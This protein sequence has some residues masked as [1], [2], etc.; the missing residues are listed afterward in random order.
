MRKGSNHSIKISLAGFVFL[1]SS[2]Q[3]VAQHTGNNY[4]SVTPVSYVRTWDVTAPEL[5]PN[6]LMARPLKDVKQTTQ[7]IDG[8]GR[9]LQTVIKMGSLVTDPNNPLSSVNATD[10][11]SPVEYDPFGREQYKWLP[12]KSTATDGNFR[13]SPFNEQPA[14]YSS[15]NTASP[16]YN[17][18]ENYFYSKTNFEPSPLNRITD[19]YAPGISWAG[20]EGNAPAQQRNVQIQYTV[21]TTNDAVR[22]WTVTDNSTIGVFGT[23][24][25]SAV[26][27]A[28]ELYKTITTD[29]HKKQVIEF[30]DK[31][32]KT[33]LRKVQLTAT[34]DD[35]SGKDYTGWL[36]TYY[37]YDD[38]GNLR[39]VIQPEGVK[40]IL[41]TWSLTQA[42]LD[43]QC[44]RY[45]YDQRNRTITKKVPGAGEVWMVYDAL[46][47]LVMTQ[48]ANMRSSSQQK[49]LY[50]IY[51][52]LNRPQS[53]GLITDPTNYNNHTAH[54]N[55]AYNSTAY[56]NVSSYTNEELTH[57]FYDDYTWLG[58]YG[59]PLPSTYATTYD[60]YFQPASN[61]EWP[62][63]QANTQSTV[64]ND[65]ATGS[66]TKILGTNNYLYTVIFYDAK[67]RVIQTQSTNITG[68]TDIN[69]TQ[70]TWAGQ[71]LVSVQKQ[72]KA[73][74]NAQTT[75]V[76]SQ[77]TYDNLGRLVK[78]E[79]KV[80]NT[81]VNSNAMPA[82]KTTVQN[83]YNALGQIKT[84]KLAPAYNSNAGLETLNYD[85]NIRGWLLGA[86]REYAKDNNNSNYFG[87][88]LGYDKVNNNIIGNQTYNNPQYN[89]NI[90][91]MVWKSK[92]DG[93]KRKYDFGYDAVNRLMKADF[94]QY[95]GSVFNQSAGVNFNVKM[96]DGTMLSDG[97]SLD[98]TKAYDDN[99]NIL[100]MQQYGLKVNTS[101]QIDNLKYTYVAGSNRLKSV[102]DFNNDPYG[103][104]GDFKTGLLHP[105]STTKATLTPNSSPSQFNAI[106]DYSYDDNGNLNL[107]NNKAINSITYNYLNLPQDITFQVPPGW[108]QYGTGRSISYVYDAA[109][110]K[111]QKIVQESAGVGVN[112]NITTTYIN[113]FVYES[114]STNQG[115]SPDP[116]DH[117]DQ[118]QFIIHEEGRIRFI[119]STGTTVAS[120]QYDYMLKD[121]LSNVRMVLT[122]EQQVD[123]Y[124]PATMETATINTESTY[125]GN[126]TNTQT[127]KP[128]WFSDPLFPTNAQ[129]ATI[130]NTTGTQKIGPNIILKV[131][132]G[133]S[134]N[135]RVASGWNSTNSPSNDPVNVL[136]D[137]FNLLSS[138]VAN[139]SGGKA[140][141]SDL[142]S[143]SSGLNSGLSNF[144]SSQTNGGSA[145]K[146]YLNW[147][148]LDE[149]FR[150]AKDASGNIIASGYSGF[151]QVGASG[152]TKIHVQTLTVAKSG[153]LY[154]YTSN[155]A[156]N[157][158]VFF[159]NLQ[160]THNKGPIMEETHYYPFGLRMEGICSKAV[161][162]I[163][164]KYQYNGKES[165][166]KEL[167]DGNGL[168]AYDYGA[169]L[170]DVQLGMWHSIDPL[171]DKSRRW[172]P[173]NYAYNNPIR[174]IDPDG[175]EG[176]DSNDD[177]DQMVNFVRVR[178]TT[179]GEETNII[180]GIAK[181]GTEASY[182]E[183]SVSGYVCDDR[184]NIIQNGKDDY[185]VTMLQDNKA[186]RLG[187]LGGVLDTR[188]IIDNILSDNKK[189]AQ[190]IGG[191]LLESDR[192][193]TWAATVFTYSKWDYKNRGEGSLFGSTIFGIAFTF[194][195]D[196][197]FKTQFQASFTLFHDAADFGNYNAGYTGIYA[198]VPE[199][200]QFFFAGMG[201]V[202][203]NHDGSDNYNNRSSAK[204]LEEIAL[205]IAPYGDQWIDY[206]WNKKGMF[207]AKWSQR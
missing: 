140:S 78:T 32:G 127:A 84:K 132:A 38:L 117:P 199:G 69:T 111:L 142:Q 8:L 180:T 29:E 7:Y 139:N 155:E 70:Y 86:N 61:S 114:K 162:R 27:S 26:Y 49:W 6:N 16:V 12:Y 80:S 79:K 175:M 55:A 99:G 71:P 172:S 62:Y 59:N 165:Q 4:T 20:S 126:L 14:F 43:D 72:E 1:L 184:G 103:T 19:A 31:A 24:A 74:T 147:V 123:Q 97:I 17:Q 23:Y 186:T 33:I 101:V 152:T 37:I 41:S 185:N 110:N 11:V 191:K 203:K 143:T 153:Y 68:G 63:P 57:V 82:Y 15:T 60:T 164:N 195:K 121:H 156:T 98:P 91:G 193:I 138:G 207:D 145:P 44:F 194:D 34:A 21:N 157:I 176:E 189:E 92:G 197:A 205:K 149:Q 150:V 118:L 177:G 40:A 192:I 137:L 100:Q 107:D 116:D 52:N 170:L 30:K 50:T 130:K 56:P 89:G 178:S 35:G 75:V 106:T 181:E 88:D 161:N 159:D 94:T 77:L 18:G 133:D 113:G 25:S 104:L 201:E 202:M 58:T 93:E 66:R 169:R 67:G 73:G 166:S 206:I 190:E 196:K 47:R 3:L 96:G 125:Y 200:W 122:E 171:A 115:G 141:Y 188:V 83:E 154:I 53:T 148:L 168:E 85:Y 183:I 5:N 51:D 102:T 2:I 146:A 54:L 198:G 36:S 10:M 135:V 76:V 42:L 90:E 112:R 95:T 108:P 119:P 45:E 120:L 167:S 179:T 158:D 163:D 131:M 174:Y 65:M 87:F 204:R 173:Y 22:I 109:G 144:M 105:Q 136:A 46:D 48:D 182:T 28:G 81:L 129:V 13:L 64:L 9:P 187:V 39:C 151:D 160:V 128:S 124:P 134:Y